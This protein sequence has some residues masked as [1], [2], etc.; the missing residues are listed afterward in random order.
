LFV[1]IVLFFGDIEQ[2]LAFFSLGYFQF[3]EGLYCHFG[4][5]G[6]KDGVFEFGD[7]S[8]H[9]LF[10]FVEI[11]DGVEGLLVVGL[12]MHSLEFLVFK[13]EYGGI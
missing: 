4:L 12:E 3:E 6:G 8:A 1:V 9:F 10:F 5:F 11:L 7:E 2:L 13:G